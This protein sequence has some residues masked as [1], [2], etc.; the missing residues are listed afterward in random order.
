MWCFVAFNRWWAL[1]QFTQR[2]SSQS[3]QCEIAFSSQEHQYN[4]K[5]EEGVASCFELLVGAG[6]PK[7]MS[8]MA[9]LMGKSVIR[10][11]T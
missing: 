8:W 3:R 9:K 11:V 4:S 1:W 10:L 7:S 5:G 2:K 6:W